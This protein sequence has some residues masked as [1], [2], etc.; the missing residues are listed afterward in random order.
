MK[1]DIFFMPSTSRDPWA[2]RMNWE[3]VPDGKLKDPEVELQ[4]FLEAVQT[5]KSSVAPEEIRKC[6]AWTEQYGFEGA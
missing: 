2:K 1:D 6:H 4:D 3:D 5:N